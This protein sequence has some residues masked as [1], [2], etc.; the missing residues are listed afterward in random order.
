MV[1]LG[2]ALAL[3]GTT[4]LTRLDPHAGYG[5]EVLPSLI[6]VGLGMGI[7]FAPSL[8][9]ATLAPGPQDRAASRKHSPPTSSPSTIATRRPPSASTPAAGS[10]GGAPAESDHVVVIVGAPA[11]G[12]PARRSMTSGGVRPVSSTCA[13]GSPDPRPATG[14]RSS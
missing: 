7:V 9:T 10:P 13:V 2:M 6:L 11:V 1:I 3:T 4:L 14:A 12:H 8:G 5:G